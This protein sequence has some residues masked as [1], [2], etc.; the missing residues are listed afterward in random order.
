MKK[1]IFT[2]FFIAT[3]LILVAC[4]NGQ[5]SLSQ[6]TFD[7]D[8]KVL[9]F[10]ALASAAL[11]DTDQMIQ[12]ISSTQTSLLSTEGQDDGVIET[13]TPYLDL[14]EKFLG[15]NNGLSVTNQISDK[16][17]FTDMIIFQTVDILGNPTTYKIYYYL[18]PLN[19][20]DDDDEVEYEIQGL[21]QYAGNEYQIYGRKEIEDDEEKIKFRA[22]LDELTYVE[23]VYEIEENEYKFKFKTYVN[24]EIVSESKIKVEYEDSELKI[25]LEYLEGPNMGEFEFKYEIEDG[26]T[27]LKIEFE[28]VLD[29]IFS[30]G[31]IKVFVITDE[32]TGETRYELIVK[33]KGSDDEKR[34]ER[35]RKDDD[36]DESE[37]SEPSEPSSPSNPSEPS[38]PNN[39][40]VDDQTDYES[41]ASTDN[42]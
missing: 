30:E 25:K 15:N 26:Q 4:Q 28:T 34:F 14:V 23:S 17:E 40:P 29:G 18:I 33:D 38:D 24:G 5:F 35:D 8:E 27:I 16:E 13:I 41:G 37:P 39:P 2:F 11:I 19:E 10:S 20:E 42:N 21:L 32:I 9:S 1:I 3:T 36:N 7:S 22:S 12:P 31:E 6:F